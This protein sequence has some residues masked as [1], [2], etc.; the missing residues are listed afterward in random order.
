MTPFG[1]LEK[2]YRPNLFWSVQ[3]VQLS[4]PTTS[5]TPEFIYF[6]IWVLTAGSGFKGGDITYLD[7]VSQS[8]SNNF[9]PSVPIVAASVYPYTNR[10]LF[11]ALKSS[12]ELYLLIK[13]TT[14]KGTFAC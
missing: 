11:L 6:M 13:C 10:P 2:F 7:A 14:Y 8:L 4:V 1:I 3:K 5:I 9:V 12:Y